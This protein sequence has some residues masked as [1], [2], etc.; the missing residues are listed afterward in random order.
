[1]SHNKTQTVTY[2]RDLQGRV[3]VGTKVPCRINSNTTKAPVQCWRGVC[4]HHVRIQPIND[5]T[6]VCYTTV[7]EI[8]ETEYL[9]GKL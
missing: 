7:E 4:S 3:F 2:Y 8:S 6:S 1:M 9:L 5:N